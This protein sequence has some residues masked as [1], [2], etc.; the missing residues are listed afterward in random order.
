MGGAHFKH[1]GVFIR[2]LENHS[3]TLNYYIIV[4][5]REEEKKVFCALFSEIKHKQYKFLERGSTKTFTG[6]F[7]YSFIW[8]VLYFNFRKKNLVFHGYIYQCILS[9]L[10]MSLGAFKRITIVNWGY[11]QLVPHS[12]NVKGWLRRL[13]RLA[14]LKGYEKV[15]FIA[16]MKPDERVLKR[17]KP[18]EITTI[19]YLQSDKTPDFLP[20][21]RNNCILLGN[22]TWYIESY[23]DFIEKIRCKDANYSI[24]IMMSYGKKVTKEE[25][26]KLISLLNDRFNNRFQII[27]DFYNTEE[28]NKLI[29]DI[30]CYVC[31]VKNQTGL[32]A[33]YTSIKIG[34]DVFLTGKN[35]IWL[36]GIGIKVFSIKDF[37]ESYPQ[38]PLLTVE[39]RKNNRR[40]LLDFLNT[41]KLIEQWMRFLCS[42]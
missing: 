10:L 21:T 18:K 34:R 11:T 35:Y 3:K 20:Y 6:K 7:F 26:N 16:L 17:Y 41:E 27:S 38:I 13:F 29:E 8:L 14:K 40:I 32:G 15:R 19:T 33:I 2:A 39:E 5:E 28:Y 23:I 24:K 37:L 42:V 4:C 12:R 9:V 31:N 25:E 36:K 22:S 30:S 1:M